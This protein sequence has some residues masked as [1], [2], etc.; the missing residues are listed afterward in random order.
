MP[1]VFTTPPPEIAVEALKNAG[2]ELAGERNLNWYLSR[3]GTY[4]AIP[5]RGAVLDWDVLSHIL[6]IAEI[7]YDEFRELVKGVG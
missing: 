2:W 7:S 6:E 4:L 1:P 3:N 5:K